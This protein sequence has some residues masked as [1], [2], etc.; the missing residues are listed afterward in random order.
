[1]LVRPK[2]ISL[3]LHLGTGSRSKVPTALVSCKFPKNNFTFLHRFNYYCS[4]RSNSRSGMGSPSVSSIVALH[5]TNLQVQTYN[6]I[7]QEYFKEAINKNIPKRNYWVV[8]SL[9]PPHRSATVCV[10]I[11]D[12]CRAAVA[13]QCYA[14]FTLMRWHEYRDEAILRWCSMHYFASSKTS[15]WKD[16]TDAEVRKS[17]K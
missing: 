16:M 11:A 13:V 9:E 2:V 15:K 8:E 6:H 7:R 3:K 10:D 5:T 14:I 12:R 4:L 17:R 1:M